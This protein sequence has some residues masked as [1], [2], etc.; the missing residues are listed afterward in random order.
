MTDTG[1]L[2]AARLII[3]GQ[4]IT[5]YLEPGTPNESGLIFVD[6]NGQGRTPQ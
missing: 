1:G 6:D 5:Q 4:V 2:T 3:G